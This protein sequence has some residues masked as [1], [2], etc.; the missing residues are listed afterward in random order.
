MLVDKRTSLAAA[1]RPALQDITNREQDSL[2][3]LIKN[4]FGDRELPGDFM[5]ISLT[6][7]EADAAEILQRQ[8]Q[9]DK[10]PLLQ[11]GH[12]RDV[13]V[14]AHPFQREASNGRQSSHEP[15]AR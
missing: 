7:M 8:K 3:H 10:S 5:S 12:R 1:S 14:P 2:E 11:A 13:V 9:A 4:D 6:Q 15:T